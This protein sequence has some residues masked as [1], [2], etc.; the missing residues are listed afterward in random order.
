MCGLGQSSYLRG[1]VAG[2]GA[3]AVA[4]SAYAFWQGWGSGKKKKR[5]R[6]FRIILVRHGESEGDHPLPGMPSLGNNRLSVVLSMN[7]H[8]TIPT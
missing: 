2:A 4:Y 6:T 3:V 7:T 1:F 8:A 5:A